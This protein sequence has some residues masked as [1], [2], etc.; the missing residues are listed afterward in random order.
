ML[1]GPE[2]EPL[3]QLRRNLEAD[4]IRLVRFGHDF[5]DATESAVVRALAGEIPVRGTLPIALSEAWPVGFGL[6]R[7]AASTQAR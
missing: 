1:T 4:G 3:T 7:P 2:G 6:Q 5:G